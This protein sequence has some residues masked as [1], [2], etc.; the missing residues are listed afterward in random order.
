MR[1][2]SL[3]Y[4]AV[5]FFWDLLGELSL[6]WHTG[7][8]NTKYISAP[9]WLRNVSFS[10]YNIRETDPSY[11]YL[12]SLSGRNSDKEYRSV[13][14]ERYVRT[15]RGDSPTWNAIIKHSSFNFETSLLW[16][17]TLMPQYPSVDTPVK[18][19]PEK[20]KKLYLMSASNVT[21]ARSCLTTPTRRHPLLQSVRCN[22]SQVQ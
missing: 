4:S 14:I 20:V 19:N 2:C 7:Q 22:R 17:V 3:G 12:G 11:W 6:I 10:P 13:R 16:R 8:K 15:R 9:I 5:R 18:S 1:F 21:L